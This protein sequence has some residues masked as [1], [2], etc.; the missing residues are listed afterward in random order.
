M[1]APAALRVGWRAL[2]LD[3]GLAV[4]ATLVAYR[5]RFTAGDA[6][7]F[8][9][10]GWMALALVVA[11]QL[12]AAWA[13][14]LYR[15]D[16]HTMWPVRLGTA[17]VGGAA[18]VVLLLAWLA[19]DQ[20]LS[21][22]AVASQVALLCLGAVLWRALVGLRVREQQAEAIRAAFGGQSLV[23]QGEDVSSMAG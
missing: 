3:A 20:G 5:L 13:L 22:Q 23:V 10:V 16:G 9:A 7:E 6:L 4:A 18:V 21:R 11:A 19:A 12:G 1:T 14:G 17:F 2:A 8:L 15:A